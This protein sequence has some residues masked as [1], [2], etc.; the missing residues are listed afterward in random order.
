MKRWMPLLILVCLMGLA[1]FMGVT[2]YFSIKVLKEHKQ[3]LQT[4]VE[5]NQALSAAMFIIVYIGVT[6]LSLP[7]ASFLSVLAGFFFIQPLCTLYVLVGAVFGALVV[8][9][10]AKTSLGS[11]FKEKLGS[12]L[13]TI[14]E[15]FEKDGAY[16]L[17]SLRFLP[18]FPF[19]MVNIAPAFL[20]CKLWTFFWTTAVGILPG[21]F[22]Y[23]QAGRGLGSILESEESLNLSSIFN[24]HM[25]IALVAL[26]IFSLV[27]I[28]VKKIKQR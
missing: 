13:K 18:I 10:V 6:S 1:Y 15:K 17:L 23:T 16:Y 11:F 22:V 2:S 3:A 5:A 8:F 26:G 28:L 21:A 7:V 14:E 12:R 20:N 4:F 24:T 25:K 9:S 27:P 19:W